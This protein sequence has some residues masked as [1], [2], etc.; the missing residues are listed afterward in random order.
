[1]AWLLKLYEYVPRLEDD[2]EL[3]EEVD[4][5]LEDTDRDSN[6]LPDEDSANESVPTNEIPLT[7]Y[8]MFR[9]RNYIWD[10][11]LNKEFTEGWLA[12]YDI[13]ECQWW[14]RAWVFQEFITSS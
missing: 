9:L 4:S 5:F 14:R 3:K 12:F 8:H 6:T 2:L 11:M 10:N 1:M 7:R 13:L